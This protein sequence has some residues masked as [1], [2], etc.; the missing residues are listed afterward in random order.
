MIKILSLF[1]IKTCIDLVS[2]DTDTSITRPYT[3]PDLRTN[4][5]QTTI[6]YYKARIA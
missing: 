1:D 5:V 6:Y 4:R 3:I 2:S